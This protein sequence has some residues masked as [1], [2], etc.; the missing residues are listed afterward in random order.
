VTL[1][2]WLAAACFLVDAWLAF[3][4]RRRRTGPSDWWDCQ[5]VCQAVDGLIEASMWTDF[6]AV[7]DGI[8]DRENAPD[9]LNS[10]RYRRILIQRQMC[11]GAA[12]ITH[13][14]KE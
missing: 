3:V 14:R 1:P 12:V 10:P 13:I 8:A 5:P 11:P 2:E 6:R 4:P 7:I 9:S